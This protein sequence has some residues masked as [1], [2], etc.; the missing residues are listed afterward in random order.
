VRIVVSAVLLAL[1]VWRLPNFDAHDLVPTFSRET[2]LW[3]A[4]SVVT[5]VVAF[6][7]QALRWDAVLVAMGHHLPYRRL[8]SESLAGQF[9]SNVLP[10]AF[11]GDIVRLARLGRDID[12]HAAAFASIALERLTGWLVL[13]TISLVA[14]AAVPEFR[15]LGGATTTA[16]VVDVVTIVALVVILAVA[17]NPAWESAALGATGWRRWL[18]SVHLGL[19]AIRRN[20]RSIAF[21]TLAGVAFQVTQCLSIWMA[22]RALQ[23]PEVTVAAAFAFFP[24]TLIGQNLPVGFGGLGVREGGFVLFFGALGASNGKA[25][26]LGLMTYLVTVVAS[27]LGAPF[28]AFGGERRRRRPV[29][30][31]GAGDADLAGR[32][33]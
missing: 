33:S 24:P 10:T 29:T 7:L 28:L 11:A 13:P 31:V 20:P 9:V 6:A 3:L 16:I 5:L 21:V 8:L 4:G 23:I 2:V 1:L 19:T 25:V 32:A 27:S 15:S 18:G 22:A 12:D 14:I 30:D 26:A 17:A